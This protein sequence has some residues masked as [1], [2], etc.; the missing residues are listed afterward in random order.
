[1]PAS[2]VDKVYIRVDPDE[3]ES[4][5]DRLARDIRAHHADPRT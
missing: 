2:L 4:V 5:V 3:P 1:M